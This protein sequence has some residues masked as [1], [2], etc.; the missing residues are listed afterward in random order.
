NMSLFMMQFVFHLI[1]Y[2][3]LTADFY[4]LFLYS[5]LGCLVLYHR[6]TRTWVQLSALLKS[7]KTKFIGMSGELGFQSATLRMFPAVGAAFVLRDIANLF[8]IT[9]CVAGLNNSGITIISVG[10][11]QHTNWR[12]MLQFRAT[13]WMLYT[14]IMRGRI[15]QKLFLSIFKNIKVKLFPSFT[16][17]MVVEPNVTTY[18]VQ[19]GLL[20]KETEL[21]MFTSIYS[22]LLRNVIAKFKSQIVIKVSNSSS[23]IEL[24]SNILMVVSLILVS[25]H[26]HSSLYSEH[27][28]LHIFQLSNFYFICSPYFNPTCFVDLILIH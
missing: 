17:Y 20:Q 14:M 16:R 7:P 25:S 1:T 23:N 21:L 15:S 5:S 8:A 12:K 11:K 22:L 13:S 28:I 9:L 18:T 2:D 19:L 3:F 4:V 6:E 24:I 27:F 10:K 26:F